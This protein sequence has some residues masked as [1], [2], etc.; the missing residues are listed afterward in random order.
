MKPVILFAIGIAVVA[1]C[2]MPALAS[3]TT[4][5]IKG[6]VID[7]ECSLSQGAAGSGESHGACAMR[8]AREGKQMAILTGDQVYLVEG[9]YTANKN[10]KLLDFVAKQVE[11]KGAVSERDGKAMINVAAMRVVKP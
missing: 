9:D 6:E 1:A 2:V 7:L 8:C 5:T 3:E 4:K 10:A 11:A